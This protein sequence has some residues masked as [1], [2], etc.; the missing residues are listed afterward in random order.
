MATSN[1]LLS[2]LRFVAFKLKIQLESS[3]ELQSQH[4]L[5]APPPPPAGIKDRPGNLGERNSCF[6]HSRVKNGVFDGLFDWLSLEATA[7]TSD[8]HCRY[9]FYIKQMQQ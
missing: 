2:R 8:Q 5:L 7:C 9:V 1:E 6:G 4:S 3:V